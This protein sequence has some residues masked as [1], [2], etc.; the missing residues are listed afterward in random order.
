MNIAK[1][2]DQYFTGE[3][4]KVSIEVFDDSSIY[5]V[6][7]DIVRML[8]A[9]PEIEL[10]VLQGMAYC[11]YEVLDNVLTHSGKNVGT[12]ILLYDEKSTRVKILVADDGIGIKSSLSMNEEYK[13]VAEADALRLCL[14]NSVTDGKGMGY[15][16]YSTLQLIR[17]VGSSL[18]IRSG[19]HQLVFNGSDGIRLSEASPWQGTIVYFELHSD[20]VLDTE[21]VFAGKAGVEEGYEQLFD[22]D[23]EFGNLW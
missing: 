23:D 9:Y 14:Q 22:D 11:F 6:Y 10:S 19:A 18:Q 17:N 7:A 5:Q 16:L 15:G 2:I 8:N 4:D 1:L 21:K 20:K 12:V 3:A 13:D